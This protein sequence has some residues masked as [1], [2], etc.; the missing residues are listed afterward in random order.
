MKELS[1]LPG[2]IR[3]KSDRLY[4][5]KVLCKYVTIY[6][7]NLYGVLYC[8]THYYTGSILIVYDVTKT[9]DHIIRHRIEEVL[10]SSVK[11]DHEEL[12]KYKSYYKMIEKREKAKSRFIIFGLLYVAF[13]I[14][15]LLCGKFSLS[16]NVKVLKIASA[17]TIVGGYPL[18]KTLYKRL[19]KRMLSD[20]DLLLYLT[21]LSFTILRESTKS[22]FVLLLKELNQYIKLSADVE[23]QRL[24]NHS[25]DKNTSMAW[26][27]N[28]HGQELLREVQTLSVGDHIRV[29]EGELIPVEGEVIEGSGIINS[30]Y[31]TGQ[32]VIADIEAGS[33][34]YEGIILVE[35][36]LELRVLKLPEVSNKP[37][38]S[39]SSLKI[40]AK[41]SRLQKMI[42]PI[43]IGAAALNFLFT[44]NILN[45]LSIIL[46]MTPSAARLALSDG[47]KSYISLLHKYNIYVRN[48]NVFEK[49]A[50]TSSIV[51]DK[52]G[53]LT[54]G[55]MKIESIHIIN[56]AYSKEELLTICA[57]C[58]V[59]NYHPI[60]ITLQDAITHKYDVGKVESSILLPS[61]GVEA[62]YDTH[63]V[64]IGNRKLLADHHIDV[65]E[66]SDQYLE[67]KN[68]YYTPIFVA[69]DHALCGIIILKD[70]IRDRSYELIQK[71]KSKGLTN[72]SIVSGDHYTS[73]SHT[74]SQLGI[75]NIFAECTNEDK[76]RIIEQEKLSHIVMMIGD[77]VNDTLA[78]KA[79]DV[80]ISFAH[81]SCDKIKLHS[82]CIIFEDNLVR[83]ADLISLTQKSYRKII[84][85]IQIAQ[86]YNF[87][88]G[89]F[90][91]FQYFD[92]FTAKSLNTLNSLIILFLNERIK[93]AIPERTEDIVEKSD[94]FT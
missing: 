93:W 68:D 24:F 42:T 2:R 19:T 28:N 53:T 34:V 67:Y 87:I 48:P 70:G 75:T 16:R 65:K 1:I 30:L 58:E 46:V 23:S 22:V 88:L 44:G 59:N 45:A 41:V 39:S 54:H 7:E 77:G 25:T 10:I 83:I 21:S 49:I 69:I 61:K 71:L 60:S 43:S 64:L 27:M 18:L 36:A 47:T 11:G 40:K 14:K 6:T 8:D 9:D 4:W 55:N 3:L 50:H 12:T 32:P 84:I 57:S 33:K 37:D 82:D 63:K 13:K 52:T 90:A 51:F 56:T 85:N 72:L 5:D 92:A 76:V 17:V 94:K 62:V 35:G 29:H 26:V 78:M 66:G 86:L 81:S 80:S 31:Y 74:A 79:A 38:I 89:F 73:M 91:L 15:Q 20:A